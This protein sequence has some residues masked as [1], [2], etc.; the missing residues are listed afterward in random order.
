[1]EKFFD[2]MMKYGFVV[3]AVCAVVSIAIGATILWAGAHF[4]AKYW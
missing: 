4:V 2:F 3:W 1:M